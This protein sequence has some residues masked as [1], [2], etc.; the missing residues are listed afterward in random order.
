MELKQEKKVIQDFIFDIEN[1]KQELSHFPHHVLCRALINACRIII[2]V[3]PDQK[4]QIME[5]V[6]GD[7]D[8]FEVGN[9]AQEMANNIMHIYVKNKD[10]IDK[11]LIREVH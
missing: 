7:I 5:E 6:D 9:M 11:A 3:D 4:S 8:L 10:E 2:K 1:T